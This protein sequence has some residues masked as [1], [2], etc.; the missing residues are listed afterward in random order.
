MLFNERAAFVGKMQSICI[1]EY[2]TRN[3]VCALNVK[4]QDYKGA[5]S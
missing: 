4:C 1:K 5:E 2:G 3:N